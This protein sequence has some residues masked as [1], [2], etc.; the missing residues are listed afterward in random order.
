MRTG[1][2]E[3]AHAAR[4]SAGQAESG[5]RHLVRMLDDDGVLVAAIDGL[6]HGHEAARASAKAV[7]A[8]AEIPPDESLCRMVHVCD[9]AL[10]GTRGAT[11]SLARFNA[12]DGTLAWVGVGNVEGRLVRRTPAVERRDGSLLLTPGLVG[13]RMASLREVT[14]PL[15]RGDVIALMTDGVLPNAAE[16]VDTRRAPSESVENIMDEGATGND[17]ALVLVARYMG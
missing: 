13:G 14:F 11:M 16:D 6:G 7:S 2:V 15:A 9:Q 8:L 5:D 3:W 4:T 12:R 1:V 17:D 10:Q